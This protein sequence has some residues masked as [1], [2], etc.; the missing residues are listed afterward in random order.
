M[1]DTSD[2]AKMAPHT[3]NEKAL[4]QL[5]PPNTKRWVIRRKAQ[6]VEEVRSGAISLDEACARY[7]LSVEEFLSW[8]HAITNHDVRGLRA[9]RVKKYRLPGSDGLTG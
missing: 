4:A 9:T 6:V 8:R 5:P 7:S 1:D 3:G 2:G